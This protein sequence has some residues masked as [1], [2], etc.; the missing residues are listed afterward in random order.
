MQSNIGTSHNSSQ[1]SFKKAK[2]P[3]R[4][5]EELKRKFK[6]QLTISKDDPFARVFIDPDTIKTQIA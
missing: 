1:H 5:P 3:Q 6:R 2:S 4:D